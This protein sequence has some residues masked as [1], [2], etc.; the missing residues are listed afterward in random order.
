MNRQDVFA[1]IA[2]VALAV[3]LL[4]SVF[5]VGVSHERE[6]TEPVY[7]TRQVILTCTVKSN[8]DGV[9]TLNDECDIRVV[10]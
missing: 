9:I 2:A 1:C 10:K 7:S 5:M 4:F 3:A 8:I 6:K